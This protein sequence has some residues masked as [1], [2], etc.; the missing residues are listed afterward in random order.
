MRWAA[1]STSCNT[2]NPSAVSCKGTE[3]SRSHPPPPDKA[4]GPPQ[5]WGAGDEGTRGWQDPWRHAG[6]DGRM[7][8]LSRV[9]SSPGSFGWCCAFSWPLKSAGREMLNPL[10]VGFSVKCCHHRVPLSGS[11]CDAGVS[12]PALSLCM[13]HPPLCLSFPTSKGPPSPSAPSFKQAPS[14]VSPAALFWGILLGYCHYGYY[15]YYYY[16]WDVGGALRLCR[17]RLWRARH[18]S[19]GR[20]SVTAP[21]QLRSPQLEEVMKQF[22][23]IYKVMC[24]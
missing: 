9:G 19:K 18:P 10:S 20:R 4:G 24:E 22:M 8:P 2:V 16:Y 6:K 21:Q 11:Q 23:G 15:Y 3:P 17:T 13:V 5:E 12:M 7:K 1:A 14:H